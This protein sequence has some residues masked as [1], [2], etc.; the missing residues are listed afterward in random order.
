M[1]TLKQTTRNWRIVLEKCATTSILSTF[2]IHRR[3][4]E[5]SNTAAS[6]RP[7]YDQWQTV[8]LQLMFKVSSSFSNASSQTW[9]PL[10]DRP[11]FWYKLLTLFNQTSLEAIDA[12]N[13]CAIHPL[14]QYAPH[15]IFCTA[16]PHSDVACWL[17]HAFSFQIYWKWCTLSYINGVVSFNDV[18]GSNFIRTQCINSCLY[19]GK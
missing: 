7:M 3:K 10:L 2:K 17:G 11:I 15:A 4:Y 13:V 5:T 18:L 6:F 14:L 9:T 8:W 19:T 12:M 1:R 16:Y